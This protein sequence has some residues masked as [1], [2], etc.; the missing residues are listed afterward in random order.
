MSPF[1]ALPPWDFPAWTRA[2]PTAQGKHSKRPLPAEPLVDCGS[3]SQKQ[4]F[5]F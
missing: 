2:G 1:W 5:E 3:L 4:P